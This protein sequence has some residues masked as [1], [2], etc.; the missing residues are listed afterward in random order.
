MRCP[1]TPWWRWWRRRWRIADF[2]M[3]EE[4]VVVAKVAAVRAAAR[5]AVE[6]KAAKASV[7]TEAA[8]VAR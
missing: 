8:K 3:E 4:M 7:V 5:A 2:A 1:R 6:K